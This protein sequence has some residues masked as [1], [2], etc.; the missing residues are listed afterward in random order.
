MILTNAC[1]FLSIKSAI[2]VN[3]I[4]LY[5][6]KSEEGILTNKIDLTIL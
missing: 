2:D 4:K 6:I 1:L 5:S 3:N